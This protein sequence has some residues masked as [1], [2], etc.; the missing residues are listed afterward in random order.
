MEALCRKLHDKSSIALTAITKLLSDANDEMVANDD[1]VN[2][3]F[4]FVW[5]KVFIA[6]KRAEQGGRLNIKHQTF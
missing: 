1:E 5:C 6:V 4:L 3:I 2:F